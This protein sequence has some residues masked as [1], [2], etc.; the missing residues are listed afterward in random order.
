MKVK[1]GVKHRDQIAGVDR[2]AVLL[3]Q[4]DEIVERG[5]RDRQWQ[6]ADRHHLQLLADAV[7]LPYFLR[8]EVAHDRAAVRD[9]LHDAALLELEQRE[10]NVAAMRAEIG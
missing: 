2:T 3:L 7:D 6:D 9:A 4:R 8:R 5:G 10:A 1:V